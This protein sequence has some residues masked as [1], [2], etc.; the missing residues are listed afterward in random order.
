MYLK[1]DRVSFRDGAPQFFS[2]FVSIN[3]ISSR[4]VPRTGLRKVFS[5]G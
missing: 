2:L 1:E 3:V 4:A 5:S